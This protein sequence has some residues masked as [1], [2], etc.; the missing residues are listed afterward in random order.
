[1]S[2]VKMQSSTLSTT[3]ASSRSPRLDLLLGD[4]QRLLHA[5]GRRS[6]S[7]WASSLEIVKWS[8]TMMRAAA[9]PRE[10][11]RSRSKRMR[12]SSSSGTDRSAGALAAE[13]LPHDGLR[14]L[15]A[16][17]VM[18]EPLDLGRGEDR[19]RPRRGLLLASHAHE[20]GGLGSVVGV[21]LGEE[22]YHHE[23]SDVEEE[24]PEDPVA[25]G[26]ESLEPEERG[27]TQQPHPERPVRQERGTGGSPPCPGPGG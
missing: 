18:D 12:I 8:S 10:A 16:H 4:P 7:C 23:E 13:Q 27:G 17:V 1:M 5:A 9:A 14:V 2:A 15:V 21:L 19:G 24:G 26:V 3:E 11:A 25:D 22:R 20:G 6:T